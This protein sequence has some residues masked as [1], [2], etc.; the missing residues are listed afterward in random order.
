M[1]C[2]KFPAI[3]R[4]GEAFIVA[5]LDELAHLLCRAAALA[6]ALPDQ[7]S[8]DFESQCKDELDKFSTNLIKDTEIERMVRQRGG[9]QIFRQAMLEYWG[10]ACAFTG[11]ALPEV[12]RASHAKPW[13]ECLS[14]A[15]RLEVF[16]A[17]C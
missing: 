3:L 17:F 10:N 4:V 8:I 7:T 15:E 11:I 9:Q 1:S 6:Q 13:L 16:N 14:D 5:N 2:A 12:L